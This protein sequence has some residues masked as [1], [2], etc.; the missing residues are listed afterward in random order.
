[1]IHI[2]E[3][4]NIIHL[5]G[6]L[7]PKHLTKLKEILNKKHNEHI[8][9]FLHNS[10]SISSSIIMF[11]QKYSKQHNNLQIKIKDKK[12][13]DLLKEVGFE[14]YVRIYYIK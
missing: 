5:K 14:K 3:E 11:L 2:K 1:M 4:H 8:I 6:N 9:L 13:F 10:V 12:L 7:K